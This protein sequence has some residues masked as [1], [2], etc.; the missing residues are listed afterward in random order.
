MALRWAD[1]PGWTTDDHA[2]ALAAFSV[3]ADLFGMTVEVEPSQARAFFEAQFEPVEIAPSGAA[4][5]TGYYEPEVIGSRQRGGAFTHP[6]YAKPDGIEPDQPWFP[7]A[8][9]RE[10]NLLA[11]QEIV[12]L[13]S[14]IEA[15]LAQVQGSIR[16]RLTEG[17]SV[18]LGFAGKNGQP[19]HSIGKELVARGVATVSEMTTD[20]IRGWCAMNPDLVEELLDTNPSFVFFRELDLPETSGPI[21]ALGRPVTAG[22]SLAVDP[23]V[24]T[25]GSPVWI[26]CESVPSRLM[27][28]QDIGSAIKGVGRGDIFVGTGDEAGRQ[29]GAINQTGRM[30]VLRR[31]S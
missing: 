5:F 1:I 8:E 28:A 6:L 19:Y 12:Y 2:A 3:T 15:F 17:G 29:A 10:R 9:I 7:R 24:I 22:R 20:F 30:I 14:A 18:R 4:H 25:L 13:D 11:G 21:G 23:D 27:I 26:D 31:R 16:V